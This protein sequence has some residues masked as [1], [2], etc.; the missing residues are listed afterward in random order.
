MVSEAHRTDMIIAGYQ[1]AV[2]SGELWEL[3]LV[4]KSEFDLKPFPFTAIYTNAL[5]RVFYD[6]S[7]VIV[8]FHVY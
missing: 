5:Y 6:D 8:A 7:I 2:R 1:L 4:L 3:C